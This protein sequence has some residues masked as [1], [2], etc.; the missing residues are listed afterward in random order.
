MGAAWETVGFLYVTGHP[1]PGAQ[2]Q[3]TF[4]ALAGFFALPEEEKRA[5][6]IHRLA[7]HRG[8]VP[9]AGLNADPHSPG[10]DLQ[11]A[12]EVGLELPEDDPAFLAGNMMYGPNVW[13]AQPAGF[14]ETVYGYFEA[15]QSLGHRL[16]AAFA[17]YLGMPEDWFEDKIRKPM[18]QLRAIYYPPQELAELPEA[19]K[20]DIGIGAHTDY[21]C[22]TILAASAPGLQVRNRSGEWIQAPPIEGAFIINIG[23]MLERWTNG[24]FVST[25]HRVINNT[26]RARYSLAFFF[27][28]D[29]DAVVECLPTCCDAAN[30][31]HYEP[32]RAGDWTTANI[33]AAYSYR[34]VEAPRR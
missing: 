32:V 33:K 10:A 2:V 26:G 31:P 14:Q 11:E 8:Y 1:V 23:D 24:R 25:I 29:Y 7:R 20:I 5:Y 18:T 3:A 12:F 19:G 13:P 15:V 27:G 6:D 21:E 30:P 4:E 34:P 22:F 17:L 28:A 9:P 16:F